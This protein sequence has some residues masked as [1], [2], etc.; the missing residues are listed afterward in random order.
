MHTLHIVRTDLSTARRTSHRAAIAALVVATT[1]AAVAC[2]EQQTAPQISV[3]PEALSVDLAVS[4]T[5]V[6]RG[7]TVSLRADALN[8]GNAPVVARYATQACGPEIVVLKAGNELFYSAA[9]P[10]AQPGADTQDTLLPGHGVSLSTFIPNVPPG[11]YEAYAR[12]NAA[13]GQTPN[14]PRVTFVVQ[15]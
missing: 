7:Q 14:T 8:K 3:G 6:T 11:T 2:S 9:L 1:F 5:T 15:P 10:C 12:F 13:N 4:P